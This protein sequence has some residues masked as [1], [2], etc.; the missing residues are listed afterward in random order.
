[1]PKVRSHLSRE[2]LGQSFEGRPELEKAIDALPTKGVLVLAEWDRAT[3][4]LID[5]IH[6]MEACTSAVLTSRCS[7]AR[8]S[9]SPRRQAA[10]SLPC[11]QAS[12]RRNAHRI[13]KRANEGRTVAIKR[14]TR[15]GRKPKLDE[16]QQQEARKRLRAGESCR[17]VAKTYRVHHS[18]VARLA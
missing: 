18:T 9:T 4:S 7:T 17:Q 3:R 12:P 8:A 14:G 11:C 15:L 6:I 13:L 10:A 2:G 16:H 1:M 5:G